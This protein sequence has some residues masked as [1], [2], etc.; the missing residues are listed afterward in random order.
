[1]KALLLASVALGFVND[2]CE[3]VLAKR[4]GS[5][6]PVR[7]NKSDFDADQDKPSNDREYSAY[8]GKDEPDQSGEATARPTFDQIG[9]PPQAAPSAPDFSKNETVDPVQTDPSTQAA[10]PTTVSPNSRLVAKKGSKWFIVGDDG[11]KLTGIAGLNEDGYKN[12]AEARAA[13]SLLPR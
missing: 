6:D 4:K 10:A 3:V 8:T 2:T 1:M 9:L 11:E 12:E 5:S 7:V 13:L